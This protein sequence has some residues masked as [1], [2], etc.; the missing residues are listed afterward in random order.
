MICLISIFA[1]SMKDEKAYRNALE[2]SEASIRKDYEKVCNVIASC[3]TI[4]Q[5]ACAVNLVEAFS[6]KHKYSEK[7]DL[8]KSLTKQLRTKVDELAVC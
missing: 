6:E 2:K 3:K 8:H 4:D 7:I 1:S 5:V